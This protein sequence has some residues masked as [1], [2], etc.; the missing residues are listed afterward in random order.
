M[1]FSGERSVLSRLPDL[2]AGD[3]VCITGSDWFG[4]SEACELGVVVARVTGKAFYYTV[5]LR[6]VMYT[7]HI[8]DLTLERRA[9]QE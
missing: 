2:E 9:G 7:I 6:G 5:L 3:L 8:S 1:G 4:R